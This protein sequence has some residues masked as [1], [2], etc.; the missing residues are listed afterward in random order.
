MKVVYH[1]S[2]NQYIIHRHNNFG[3]YYSS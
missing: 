2:L 1:S 3:D